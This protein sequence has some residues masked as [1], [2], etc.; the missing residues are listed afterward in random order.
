MITKKQYEIVIG[1]IMGDVYIQPTGKKNA[2]LRFEHSE[3]QK[4]YIEWKWQE[5]KNLMQDKPKKIIRYNP[6]WKKTYTYY[7]CQTHSS[8]IFGKLY[9][10]FYIDRQK[11]IPENFGK[12]FKSDL[13]LAVWYMEDGYY[14]NRDKT[15]YIYLSKVSK[16]E[17]E[18][19]LQVLN[20]NF[21]LNPRLE[22]KRLENINLKFSVEETKK[23]IKLIKAEVIPS[24][25]YKLPLPE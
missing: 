12:L 10:L 8:P 1:T 7:R 6:I 25:K 14:Y 3:K 11:V 9:R 13:S 15:A 22:T 18:N 21:G 16:K 17:T 4:S 2:R 19:L 5:L 23:L 20:K 24:M